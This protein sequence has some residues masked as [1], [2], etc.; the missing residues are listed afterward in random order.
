MK[1]ISLPRILTRQILVTSPKLRAAMNAFAPHFPD[2]PVLLVVVHAY[3]Y[4]QV[5][6]NVAIALEAGA[7]GV[8]LIAGK[9]DWETLCDCTEWLRPQFPDAWIGLNLLD[10]EPEDAFQKV[11]EGVNGLWADNAGIGDARKGNFYAEQIQPLREARPD[12]LY[13]GGV[14]FKYQPAVADVADAARAAL[15]FVDVV[16]TSG[17]GTSEA[18][19]KAKIAA[20]KTAIG[21]SPLAIASGITPE[22]VG[23]Y[24]GICDCFLVATGISSSVSELDP[25]RVIQLARAIHWSR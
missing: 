8:F 2:A 4:Q 1:L 16:T 7:D 10:L 18:P 19:A 12:L 15:P 3:S 14:A 6:R 23:N 22:N 9:M 17:E 25:V 5:E 24:L 21:A 11:P 20:M 13:F